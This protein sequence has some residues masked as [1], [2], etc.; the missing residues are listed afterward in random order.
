MSDDFQVAIEEG[1]DM[2]RLGRAI[3]NG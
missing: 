1:A 2:I 3:F